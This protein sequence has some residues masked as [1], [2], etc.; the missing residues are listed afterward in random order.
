MESGRSVLPLLV[1]EWADIINNDAE[2]HGNDLDS[3]EEQSTT[4][5]NH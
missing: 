4:A 5:N 3:A 1:I 2:Q